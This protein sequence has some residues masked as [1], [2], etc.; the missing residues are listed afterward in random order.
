MLFFNTYYCKW[1]P[2]R[3]GLIVECNQSSLCLTEI[4]SVKARL[5]RLWGLTLTDRNSTLKE[6]LPQLLDAFALRA[7]N[8]K[9]AEVAC[10]TCIVIDGH[11]KAHRKI[12]SE[13]G[14]IK[15]PKYQSRCCAEHS[16]TVKLRS[17][18]EEEQ[19]LSSAV[20]FYTWKVLR[21]LTRKNKRVY[22]IEWKGY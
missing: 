17:F 14:C 3:L 1:F 19:I 18:I 7:A 12:C 8:H 21:R 4:L 13:K 6:E 20:E 5:D 10:K 15:D 9:C 11:L 16:N 22:E 2:L